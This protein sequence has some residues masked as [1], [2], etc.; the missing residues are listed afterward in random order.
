MLYEVPGGNLVDGLPPVASTSESKLPY[1]VFGEEYPRRVQGRALRPE[2]MWGK[3]TL[4][5]RFLVLILYDL[6]GTPKLTRVMGISCRMQ[7]FM[8]IHAPGEKL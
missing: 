7:S 2:H 3:W 6:G 5:R 8:A 4:V 1:G